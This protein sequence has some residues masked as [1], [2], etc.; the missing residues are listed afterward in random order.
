MALSCHA[1]DGVARLFAK[2][3][4]DVFNSLTYSARYQLLNN[5]TSGQ[6]S[7]VLNNLQTTE[8]RIL[9]LSDDHMV[10]ATS[11]G[12]TV[13]LKLLPVSKRDT[14]IAVIE[15]VKTPV[16]DS[17][18]SFYD[19][20]WTQLDASRFIDPP[21]LNDFIVPRAG[22]AEREELSRLVNFAMIELHFED[23][24]LVAHCNLEDFFMGDDFKLFK[25]IV[26]DRVEYV[27]QKGKLKKK[28]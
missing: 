23:V 25:P 11:A 27:Y 14:V 24:N 8:S 21:S 26:V 9:Q 16:K 20:K 28:K 10:V 17:R 12:M 2:A 6:S 1:Y 19:M 15:T 13:E 3:S 4:G 22:K 18:I 7:E 5:Y